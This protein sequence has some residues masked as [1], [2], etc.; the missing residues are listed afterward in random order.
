[1]RRPSAAHLFES[2][3]TFVLGGVDRFGKLGIAT[4]GPPMSSEGQRPVTSV[5]VMDL[6]QPQGSGVAVIDHDGS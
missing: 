6:V 5:A 3:M 1:M 2:G 4:K